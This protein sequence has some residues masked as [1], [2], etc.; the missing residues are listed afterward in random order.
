MV[1]FSTVFKGRQGRKD[2]AAPPP[3]VSYEAEFLKAK[4]NSLQNLNLD[5]Y[6]ES[7]RLEGEIDGEKNN[8]KAMIGARQRIHKNLYDGFYDEEKL[9]TELNFLNNSVE[10]RAQYHKNNK[11]MQEQIDND[12]LQKQKEIDYK[13]RIIKKRDEKIDDLTQDNFMLTLKNND[14]QYA[15]DQ[16]KAMENLQRES[17]ALETKKDYEKYWAVMMSNNPYGPDDDPNYISI[18]DIN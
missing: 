9:N 1:N 3:S 7:A 5:A 11:M 15:D 18:D 16:L 17:R 12:N 10:M 8:Y 2:Q 13:D 4:L 14:L 6:L